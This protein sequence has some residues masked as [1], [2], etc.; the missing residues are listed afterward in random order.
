MPFPLPLLLFV[1]KLYFQKKQNNIKILAQMQRMDFPVTHR[2]MGAASCLPSKGAV[3]S[4]RLIAGWV[5][6]SFPGSVFV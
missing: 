6:G 2:V 5:P 4:G 3:R 1:Q